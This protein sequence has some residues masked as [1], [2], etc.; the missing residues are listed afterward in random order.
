M[1]RQLEDKIV[2]ISLSIINYYIN[3]NIPVYFY[4][5]NN[6]EIIQL[7]GHDSSDLKGFLEFLARFKA[8]GNIKFNNF[9]MGNM[10]NSNKDMAIIII[11]PPVL[12]KSM[13]TLGIYLKN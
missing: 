7:E 11:T 5:Q 3:Q 13:G 10:D 8:N 4:T 12:D 6:E 1:D 2:D 9:L